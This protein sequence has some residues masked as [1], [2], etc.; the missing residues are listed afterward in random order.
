M[1][2]ACASGLTYARF[3]SL[4]AVAADADGV[5]VVWSARDEDG[6]AKIFASNRG[7]SHLGRAGDTARLGAGRTPD[8]PRHR[9]RRR[10]LSVVFQDS[11]GDAAY[12]PDLPPGDTAAGV[13]WVTT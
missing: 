5:H 2:L 13:I 12:S 6:Q 8:L 4:S 9:F 1:V 11:R 10:S 3:S 7:R